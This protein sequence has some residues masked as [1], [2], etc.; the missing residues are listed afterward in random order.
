ML[1]SDQFMPLNLNF[2]FKIL[3]VHACASNFPTIINKYLSGL[4]F[5]NENFLQLFNTIICKIS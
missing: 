5:S 1:F 4:V 3:L 2:T